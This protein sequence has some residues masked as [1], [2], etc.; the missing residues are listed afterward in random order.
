M[1]DAYGVP[2]AGLPHTIETFVMS[3]GAIE[4]FPYIYGRLRARTRVP[5]TPETRKVLLSN[6]GGGDMRPARAPRIIYES[7]RGW[8]TASLAGSAIRL[9]FNPRGLPGGRY[10]ALVTVG[11]PGALN[12]P[13]SFRVVLN[14]SARSPFWH[15]AVES[16]ES[17]RFATPAFWIAPGFPPY[18]RCL[19]NGRRPRK[20]EFVR[21][22]PYLWGGVY[23]VRLA[24]GIPCEPG[25]RFTVRVRAANGLRTLRVEPARSTRIGTFAFRHGTGGWVEI[26]AGGSKGQVAASSVLFVRTGDSPRRTWDLGI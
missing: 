16:P 6:A 26:E 18:D 15:A 20:G 12:S 19:I 10:R 1:A 22:T 21:F 7:G 24:S 11:A 23:Q 8:L 2:P 3:D 5:W 17:G 4:L 25:T 13:Q 9:G 14:A